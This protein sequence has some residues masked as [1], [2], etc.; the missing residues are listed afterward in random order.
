MQRITGFSGRQIATLAA[1]VGL[2]A[3]LLP[4]GARAAGSLVTI[5]DPSGTNEAMVDANGSL[6]VITGKDPLDVR[7][8]SR[9]PYQAASSTTCPSGSGRCTESFAPAGSDWQ[10]LSISASVDRQDIDRAY[11]R[12][13]TAGFAIGESFVLVPMEQIDSRPNGLLHN[14]RTFGG[15]VSTDFVVPAD[16]TLRCRF[17][18]QG[19]SGPEENDQVSASGYL[20]S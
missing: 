19:G 5:T 12:C 9:T 15:I 3:L 17:A 18:Y 1:M 13:T 7:D 20:I 8:V 10:V 11:A 6:Q 16:H 2:L 4:I 14:I